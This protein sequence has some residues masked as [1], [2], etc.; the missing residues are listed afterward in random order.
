[1]TLPNGKLKDW[2]P[3]GPIHMYVVDLAKEISAYAYYNQAARWAV[4]G[5]NPAGINDTLI[6]KFDFIR[7]DMTCIIFL[8]HHDS[9]S[10]SCK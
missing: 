10:I 4:T 5:Y 9:R 6:Y 1:M 7:D 2:P 8:G 3:S